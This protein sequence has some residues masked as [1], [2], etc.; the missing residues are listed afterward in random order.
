MTVGLVALAAALLIPLRG[1]AAFWI[2]LAVAL[3]LL[4]GDILAY[5]MIANKDERV[6]E[7]HHIKLNAVAK[8]AADREKKAAAK[9][10]GKVE[11]K[12][13]SAADKS[14]V[15]PPQIDT[16]EFEIRTTAESLVLKSLAGRASQIDLAQGAKDGAY[17]TS[18]LIDG[19]RPQAPEPV[20]SALAVKVIDFWKAAAKL[21]LNDRRKRLSGD[22]VVE[23][24]ETKTRVRVQTVGGQRGQQLTLLLDPEKQV[25]R[26]PED[27]GMLEPQMKAMK[28]LADDGKGVVLLA[29]NADQGRTTTLYSVLRMHDAYTSNIQ[30]VEM[31]PQDSLEGVRQNAF[32]QTGEGP[33]YSTFVRSILRRDPQVVGVAELPDDATA[34]EIAKG[35]HE[36]TRTYLSVKTDSAMTALQAYVKAVGDPE[37]AAKSLS[38]VLAQKL[39]RKLCVNCRVPYSPSAEMLKTLGVPAGRVQQLFKKGGQ[40]MIKNKPEVCPVCQGIGYVGQEGVFEVYPISPAVRE[41]IKA[42]NWQGVQAEL[43]K[44]QYST[45]K[46]AA[47]AKVVLGVT[48]IE[49]LGR[50]T[51]DGKPAAAKPA[52]AAGAGGGAAPAAR[53]ASPSNPQPPKK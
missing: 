29:A 50:I 12:I 8:M 10:Q 15:P 45:I 16:P 3:V 36:R 49:E 51:Q 42:G 30:T 17:A 7:E 37:L 44:Q 9:K 14:V 46:Q 18:M 38:G 47:I 23:R 11:L 33:E 31:E 24:G 5:P 28:S 6:P 22:V 41:L 40:V 19:T 27:L 39:V 13:S 48:S 35:D 25:R 21:D 52:A 1:E 26:K 2:G 43:R 4:G 34:K 20:A 32:E 53:P